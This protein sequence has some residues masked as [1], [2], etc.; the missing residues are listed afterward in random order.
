MQERS[1][2]NNEYKAVKQK[3]QA[4]SKAQRTIEEFLRNERSV[5]EQKRKKNKNGDLE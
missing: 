4:L 2:K 5:Q 1:Q 3:A